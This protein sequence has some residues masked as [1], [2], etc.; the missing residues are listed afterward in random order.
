[1]VLKNYERIMLT[2]PIKKQ[3]WLHNPNSIYYIAW[4][5]G[6]ISKQVNTHGSYSASLHENSV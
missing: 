6:V 5:F 3:N 1:M 4:F 2:Q